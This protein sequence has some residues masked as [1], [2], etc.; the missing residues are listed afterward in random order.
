MDCELILDVRG[1]AY[2]YTGTT[3][4]ALTGVSLPAD[5]L[6]TDIHASAEYRAHAVQVMTRRLVAAMLAGAASVKE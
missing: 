3:E 2:R 1:V 5:G 4:D 6:N